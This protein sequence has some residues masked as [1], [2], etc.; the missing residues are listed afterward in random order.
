MK[1]GRTNLSVA[2]LD[3]FGHIAFSISSWIW[4]SYYEHTVWLGEILY[5]R[6]NDFSQNFLTWILKNAPTCSQGS[7]AYQ[8]NNYNFTEG[9]VMGGNHQKIENFYFWIN[10]LINRSINTCRML[11]FSN[12]QF[13][14]WLPPPPI[15]WLVI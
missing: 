8:K 1:N 2:L 5:L 7:T 15:F 3:F 10:F 9:Y 14:K 13:L 6:Y 12:F 11:I 4:S